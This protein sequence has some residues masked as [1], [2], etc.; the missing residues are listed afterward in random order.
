MECTRRRGTETTEAC[1]AGLVADA[2]EQ[3]RVVADDDDAARECL[4][5]LRQRIDGLRAGWE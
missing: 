4:Q 1:L 2:A 3:L 5:R